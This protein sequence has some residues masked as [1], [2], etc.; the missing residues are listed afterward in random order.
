MKNLFLRASAIVA[1]A[2]LAANCTKTPVTPTEPSLE[3]TISNIEA[4]TFTVNVKSSDPKTLYYVGITTRESY[5]NLGDPMAVAE[6]FVQIANESGMVDWT[7]ADG[8]FVHQGDLTVEAGELWT[9]K[10]KRNYAILAFGVGEGGEITLDPVYEFVTT[11]AVAPSENKLDVSVNAETGIV[12]VTAANDDPYFLDCIEADRLTDVPEERLAEHIIGIYGGLIDNCI[13]TGSVERD[14]SRILEE[15]TDYYAVVFGYLGGYPTTSVTLVPFH[16]A[17]GELVPQDCTFDFDI[18]DITMTGASITV[19]PSNAS[20]TYFWQVYNK[21]LVDSYMSGEGLDRLM[22]DGLAIIAE[23][24][25]DE[26]GF[27]ITP[28]AAASMVSVTGNDSFTYTTLDASTEYYVVA[29]G[30]DDKGRHTTEVQLSEPFKTLSPSSGPEDPMDCTIKVN[31]VTDEGLSVSV[32]PTDKEM[33]YVGMVGEADFYADYASDAEYLADDLA[34]WAEMAAAEGISLPELFDMFGL[35]L[36]GDQT[37][38]FS[39]EID[40]VDPGTLYMAYTFGL[41]SEGELTTGM[42]KVFFTVD[43]NGDAHEAEAPAQQ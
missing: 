15:D 19:M 34:M 27:E 30:L 6:G 12:T 42:Q 40:T 43:E 23:A 28:E 17:G 26:Y 36:Q 24:L 16:S 3:L 1:A 4:T 41:S 20:T 11:S 13:E 7:K 22:D 39:P 29:V 14:F 32:V 2:V 8:E 25:S 37:F 31:G 10:P 5:D 9:I 38:I 21:P 33:T 35:F 18:K